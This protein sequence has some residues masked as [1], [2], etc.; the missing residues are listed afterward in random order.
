MLDGWLDDLQ[1]PAHSVVALDVPEDELRERL[2]R[3]G[4]PDDTPEVVPTASPCGRAAGQMSSPGIR[5]RAAWSESA[6][7][8]R[9]KLW[10]AASPPRSSRQLA[11]DPLVDRHCCAGRAAAISQKLVT[12]MYSETCPPLSEGCRAAR[13]S[14][15]HARRAHAHAD[16]ADAVGGS[17][18]LPRGSGSARESAR[19]APRRRD[20]RLT[21]AVGLPDHLSPAG[22]SRSLEPNSRSRHAER[23]SARHGDPL[24]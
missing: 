14:V 12:D 16:H 11:S 7:L 19:C 6:A 13:H 5:R 21:T 10:L 4:R 23:G 1:A 9:R 17:R 20:S 2:L 3:R 18:S 22:G 8:A 24:R 15:R